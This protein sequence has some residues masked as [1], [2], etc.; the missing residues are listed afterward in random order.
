[1]QIRRGAKA[2]LRRNSDGKY[3]MLTCSLWPEN[4]RRSQKPDLPGGIIE[5]YEA[6]EEGLIREIKEETGL[7]LDHTALTLGFCTTY[8]EHEM[9]TNFLLYVGEVSGSEEIEISWEHESFNWLTVDE[10]LTLEIRAPYAEIFQY[11]K[12]AN[13]VS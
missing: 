8:I 3:L 10:L 9:S 2:L 5:P 13:L 6:I 7:T 1:M 4:P 11:L 12:K